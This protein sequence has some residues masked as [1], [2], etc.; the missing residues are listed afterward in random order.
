MWNQHSRLLLENGKVP[1]PF[2]AF[3]GLVKQGIWD[4][5]RD[6]SQ[7]IAIRLWNEC[8]QRG[9][10]EEEIGALY[11]VDDLPVTFPHH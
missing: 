4:F 10:Q 9:K 11:G 3:D 6:R 7:G 5:R 1:F 8:H 2:R